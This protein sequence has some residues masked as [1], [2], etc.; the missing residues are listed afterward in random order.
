MKKISVFVLLILP[1]ALVFTSALLNH[2]NGPY[3]LTSNSDPGYTYLLSSIALTESKQTGTNGHPGTTLQILGAAVLKISHALNF[4]E[5]DNLE[6]SVLKNPEFYLTIINIV[7]LTL[8]T[9]LLFMIGIITFKLTKNIWASLLLQYSPFLFH[10]MLIYGLPRVSTDP[11]LLFSG[12]LFVLI[13]T[14]MAFSKNLAESSHWYMIALALVAG[15]GVATK[16]IFAPLLIIPLIVLPKLRNKIGF[17]F[18]AGLSFVLWTWPIISQYENLFTWYYRILTHGGTYGLGAS[19]IIAAEG[20][21]QEIKDLFFENIL[22]FVIWLVSAGFILFFGWFLTREDKTSRK[23]VWQ[24]IS[25]K[26]LTAVT[27]AQMFLIL[28]TVKHPAGRYLFPAMGLSG[29]TLFLM[30]IYLQR[31]DY[32]NRFNIK[33]IVVFAGVIL[34]FSGAWRMV[35]IKNTFLQNVQIR[36]EA[37]AVYRKME[38]E[39]KNYLKIYCI[40]LSSSPSGALAFGNYYVNEGLFSESLQKIYGDVYFYNPFNKKFYDWTREFSIE[41]TILKS[42]GNRIVFHFPS[43]REYGETLVCNKGSILHLRD[44]FEGQYETIYVL[45][46]ITLM[47]DKDEKPVNPPSPYPHFSNLSE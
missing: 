3:W 11:L 27:V 47:W 7:V 43:L 6:I 16:F 39:Y 4:S 21:S 14:K 20:Y 33:K 42:N 9:L 12:L 24:E 17:L 22:F 1:A 26:I 34:I 15:F 13:L 8:N 5:K 37:L 28:V 19:G 31:R 10:T 45:E 36:E 41:D 38:N 30:F 23:A 18:L 40:F 32:F 46:G 25:F 35:E 44:V 29:F 2:A